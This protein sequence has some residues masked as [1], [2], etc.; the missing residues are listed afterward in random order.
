MRITFEHDLTC[1]AGSS[2]Q[3]VHDGDNRLRLL[4][5][6]EDG[7]IRCREAEPVLG[8]Y[9]GLTFTERGR[10]SPDENISLPSLKRVAHYGAY[11]FWSAEGDHRFV[12]YMMPM[13]VS[14]ALVS[15]SIHFSAGSEVS[16]LSCELLNIRGE[17]LNRNRA[18]VTPGTKLEVWFSLGDSGEASLGVYYIDRASVA[19][20]KEQVSVSA[21]NAI[22]KLLK[23][24]T[25]DEN[26]T[27][28]RVELQENIRAIL[29][30]AG[31]EAYFVGD[32]GVQQTLQFEPTTKVLEGLKYAIALLPGW[33]IAETLDGVVGIAAA[34]D[35]RFDQPDVYTFERDKTCWSYSVE[36]DD[37]DAASRVCVT[38]KVD[39]KTERR[40]YVDVKLNKW[41]TQPLHRTLYAKTVDNATEEQMTAIANTLAQSLAVSGRMETFAGLFTPQLVLGDEVRVVDEKGDMEVVGSVTD[42]TH[43][44]GTTGFST[45]F[46]VDSGGRR[47]RVRLK[48]LITT[49]AD[50]PQAFTGTSEYQTKEE[51]T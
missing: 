18:L 3:A 32:P 36:Y 42:V 46:T 43:S 48:D 51:T 10:C 41:W 2:P 21:R 26:V 1:G 6:S 15:G 38:S 28:D 14:N 33:K 50:D 9:G 45:S 23:E 13:D 39:D 12:I 19:Y 4:Y 30:M 7:L 29:D 16:S 5:L 31:V 17:L 24:Q 27:F 47:G 25:F 49:A 8:L 20:P 22:G 37:A 11:G 44:F 40:V 34:D 35:P